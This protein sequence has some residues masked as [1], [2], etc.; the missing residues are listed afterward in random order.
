[1]MLAK[2]DLVL[3]QSS[4]APYASSIYS[5]MLNVPSSSMYASQSA[6]PYAST[7]SGTAGTADQPPDLRPHLRKQKLTNAVQVGCAARV[8]EPG[9]VDQQAMQQQA[10]PAMACQA[11]AAAGGQAGLYTHPGPAAGCSGVVAGT[12]MMVPIGRSGGPR[13]QETTYSKVQVVARTT[14]EFKGICS[15][16]GNPVYNHQARKKDLNGSYVHMS[17]ATPPGVLGSNL[18]LG[19]CE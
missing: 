1:M 2:C 19:F 11:P 6:A 16:C 9:M 13:A 3:E 15:I 7:L 12:V 17:C 14:M 8:T 4:A 5:S 10:M 18:D